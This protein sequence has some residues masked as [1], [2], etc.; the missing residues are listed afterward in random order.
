MKYIFSTLFIVFTQLGMSQEQIEYF[1]QEQVIISNCEKTN[2]KA[3]CF[4]EFLESKTSKFLFENRIKFAKLGIDTLKLGGRLVINSQNQIDKNKSGFGINI[5]KIN[6]SL[7]KKYESIFKKLS[8]NGI[9]NRK[10]KPHISIHLF[11]FKYVVRNND[12]ETTFEKIPLKTPYSG[13]LIQ[14]IPR[15]PGCF[16]LN[17]EQAKICFQKKMQEH[18]KY[19][20]KYPNEAQQKRISGKVSIVFTISKNGKITNIRTKGPHPILE[21]EAVRIIQYL[22]DMEPAKQ[23]GKPVKIPYSIPIFFKLQ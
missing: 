11:D 8:I 18:I 9:I 3:T 19:H 15:F 20:F 22:P 12:G 7:N 10:P 2:D 5:K 4:Y 23:N 17:E 21:K 16:N 14:E 13:G 1:P 6:K